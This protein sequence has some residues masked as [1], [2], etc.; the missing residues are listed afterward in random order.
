MSITFSFLKAGSGDAI[1]ISF[2]G[3]NI[4]IDGGEVYHGFIDEI[5]KIKENNQLI[6]LMVL[7]HIDSDH[8]S[9]FLEILEDYS[10]LINSIWFNPFDKAVLFPSL[11]R[12]NETSAKQGLKF[13][14]FVAAFKVEYSNFSYDDQIFI[15]AKPEKFVLFPQLEVNILSPNKEKLD[16]L[17]EKYTPPVKTNETSAKKRINSGTIEELAQYKFEKDSSLANAASIALLLTYQKEYKFLLLADADI[18]LV[19]TTLKSLGYSKAN[20]LKVNFV[21]LSHHGSKNNLNQAF[22][23]IVETDS[24]VISTNGERHFHPNTE[25][26]CKIITNPERTKNQKIKFYFNYSEVFGELN[27]NLVFK[28]GQKERY[29]FNFFSIEDKSLTFGN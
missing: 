24:F 6:D 12:S 14:K 7:T 23:D 15:E 2:D 26:L 1:L 11:N 9:G 8:I 16:T 4:L 18:E 13:Q 22:L 3:K 19:T 5:E 28:N 25:T 21:K 27:Q 17:R 20:K 29:N 10:F